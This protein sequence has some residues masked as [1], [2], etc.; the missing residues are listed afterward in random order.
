MGVKKETLLA[1]ERAGLRKNGDLRLIESYL[2]TS[3][4]RSARSIF[5]CP[6]LAL[7]IEHKIAERRDQWVVCAL[8]CVLRYDFM[9]CEGKTKLTEMN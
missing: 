8:S 4:S 6:K 1:L 2:H 7:G 3:F 5:G 9:A